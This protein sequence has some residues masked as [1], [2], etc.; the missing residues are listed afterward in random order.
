MKTI[1]ADRDIP[2]LREFLANAGKVRYLDA[3]DISPAHLEDAD[4]LL[5]RSVTRVDE[6]LLSR[7]RVAFVGSATAGIDHID[8]DYLRRRGIVFRHAPGSNA[9]S[10]ADYI[11][12]ALYRLAAERGTTLRE[13]TCGVVGFGNVGR[14]VAGRLAAAGMAVVVN[15]PPLEEVDRNFAQGFMIASL[16]EV[17]ADCDVI[18][19]HVPLTDTDPYPTRT[20]IGPKEI[21]GL[22]NGAWLVNTARGE[23]VHSEALLRG[24]VEGH[25]DA[26]VLDVYESEP[27]VDHRLVQAARIATP[28]IA[29][30][31]LDSKLA[32]AHII[33]DA[34]LEHLGVAGRA[35]AAVVAGT[36]RAGQLNPPPGSLDEVAW[37][38]ALITQMYDV[39]ADSTALKGAVRNNEDLASAFAGLRRNY[40]PRRLFSKYSLKRD[41]IPES[42]RHI[43][44][45]LLVELD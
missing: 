29:G 10:V 17:I 21:R 40:P 18:T 28:H 1:V 20:F 11:L 6:A 24:V 39:D 32:G 42:C 8:A 41:R 23:V 14:R 5:V 34:V 3:R 16:D 31:A 38:D 37:I 30:Y 26:A 44:R 43:D 15:D 19:L 45:S 22:K 25:I 12:A 7:S 4:I 13:R 36:E 2:F 35:E 27:A 33:A 9:E